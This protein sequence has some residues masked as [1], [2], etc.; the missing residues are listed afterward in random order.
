MDNRKTWAWAVGFEDTFIAQTAQ[1]ERPLDEFELTEHYRYWREDLDRV[2]ASGVTMI[3]YGIPWYKVEPE[4]GKFDWSWVDE[5]IAYFEQHRDLTPIIDFMHYGTPLWLKNEFLNGDYPKLVARYVSVFV[6]RYQQ[7]TKYYTPLNEPFINAEWC[8]WSGTWPPYLKGQLGFILVMNQLCKGIIYTEQAIRRLQPDAIT[9][10]VEASKKYL[11]AEEGM[12]EEVE[13]WNE[14]RYV[15][16][17]L[18]QGKIDAKHSLYKW[19]T[20]RGVSGEDLDWYRKYAI[21]PDIIG[22]NYYPQFSVNA[23]TK[24]AMENE[25]IP[26]AVPGTAKEL[27]EI[28]VDMYHRYKKPIFIT[29]TSYCGTVEERIAWMEELFEACYFMLEQGIELYGVTWFPFFDMIG[30]SYRTNR[31]PIEQNLATFGLYTLE[32]QPDGTLRRIKNA[33]ADRFEAELQKMRQ[34]VLSIK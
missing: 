12:D 3:R 20:D 34:Q 31:L 16:W 1:G 27:I 13:L 2:R 4:P 5:V 30:W 24:E 17:E 18:I 28:A 19:V 32:K 7:V 33:A 9:V 15:M 25:Q 26:E 10:H 29:E 23:I 14:V 22:I 11:S 8:G 21:E 6:L